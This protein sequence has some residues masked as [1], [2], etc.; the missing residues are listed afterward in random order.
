MIQVI[1]LLEYSLL[2]HRLFYFV[3]KMARIATFYVIVLLF[4]KDYSPWL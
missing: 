2:L 1:V 3:A 4:L